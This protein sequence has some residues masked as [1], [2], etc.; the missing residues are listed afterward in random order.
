MY[1]KILSVNLRHHFPLPFLSAL[2]VCF[3]AFMVFGVTGLAEQEAAMSLEMVVCWA[4]P[5][6]LTPVF[7]PEQNREIRDVVQSKKFDYLLLCGIRAGYSAAALLLCLSVIAGIM[8][9]GECDVSVRL[10]FGAAAT[11]LF[12]GAVGFLAAGVSGNT[13]VGYMAAMIYYLMNYGMRERLGVFYLFGMR[14]GEYEGK[15]WLFAGAAALLLGTFGIK[16]WMQREI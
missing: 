5:A 11:A 16:I 6:L 3:L 14:G 4:G 2:G 9:L 12:L 13:T 7:L 10:L 1:G 15:G 8:R